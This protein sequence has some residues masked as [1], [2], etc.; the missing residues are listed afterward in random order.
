MPSPVYPRLWAVLVLLLGVCPGYAWGWWYGSEVPNGAD[1]IIDEVRW[2]QWPHRTYYALWNTHPYP[3]GGYLYGGVATHGPGEDAH[4]ELVWTFWDDPSYQPDRV[5]PVNHG[6]NAYGGPMFGEGASCNFTGHLNFMEQNQWYRFVMRTW[7]DAHKPEQVGYMGWWVKDLKHDRWHHV[8]IVRIPN[9]VTG[10]RGQSCFVEIIGPPGKRQIDRRGSYHHFKGQWHATR[11]ITQT[12]ATGKNSTW[13]ALEDGKVWRFTNVPHPEDSPPLAH[14]ELKDTVYYPFRNQAPQPDLE[15]PRI[16]RVRAQRAGDQVLV[17]W[18][19][20]DDTPP[21]L[22]YTVQLL[23]RQGRVLSE[24]TD[25]RPEVFATRIDGAAKAESVKLTLRDIYNQTVEQTVGLGA[26]RVQQAVSGTGFYSGVHYRYYPLTSEG[27][28]PSQLPDFKSIQPTREG[29]ARSLNA[30]VANDAT[31]PYALVYDG[32]IKV[33]KAGVYVFDL[34][35]SDGSRLSIGG[36][37]VVNND[38]LHSAI[39][40]RGGIALEAGYHP[41]QLA[42]F[43]K[44]GGAGKARLERKL[45][46]TWEGPDIPWGPIPSGALFTAAATPPPQFEIAVNVT[47]DNVATITPRIRAANRQ[48]MRFEIFTGKARVAFSE[49]FTRRARVKFPMPI[50]Q[51]KLWGRLWLDGKITVESSEVEASGAVPAD[52]AWELSRPGEDWT[53]GFSESGDEL[54][55]MGDGKIEVTRE[56]KG[57]FTLTGRVADFTPAQEGSGVYWKSRLGLH[58]RTGQDIFPV[59]QMANQDM[60]GSAS[61]RDLETSGISRWKVSDARPWMRLVRRGNHLQAYVSRDQ[62]DW[63]LVIDRVFKSIPETVEAGVS[64]YAPPHYSKT[65][66][67]GTIDHIRIAQPGPVGTVKPTPALKREELALRRPIRVIRGV[68]SADRVYLRAVGPH[69]YASDDQGQTWQ[70]LRL[71]AE[72]RWVRSLAVHPKDHNILL[73]GA[74][75]ET[76]GGATESGLWRSTDGGGTWSKIT[77]AIDFRG[78]TS[79]VVCGEVIAFDPFNPGVVLAGGDRTGV[80]VST[81]AGQTWA[82]TGITDERVLVIAFNPHQ[83][84]AAS[85]GTAAD[86]EWGTPRGD[87]PGRIYALNPKQGRSEVQFERQDIAINNIEFQG[88]GET[89]N[90]M[91]FATTRGVYYCYNRQH[92]FNYRHN[93]RPDVNH[94][95]LSMHP[96]S[97]PKFTPVVTAPL[98]APNGPTTYRGSINYYW[99]VEWNPVE[100]KA[101]LNAVTGITTLGKSMFL[102]DQRGLWVSSDYGKSYKRVAFR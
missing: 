100:S 48:P 95:G 45:D 58:I 21:Q 96:G 27:G 86:G 47:P 8:G 11:A 63:E 26:L 93:I 71:P 77:D 10:M 84:T 92:F 22:G 81:D 15:A 1:I 56:V 7:Q 23:D 2:P 43:E 13:E 78:D 42:Y 12:A 68:S 50:G 72:A 99:Q 37:Q 73:L 17:S 52:S 41:F 67:R 101:K 79:T 80:H 82:R 85:I 76:G 18:T 55:L 16:E 90:Y 40:R 20:P 74:G 53:A 38:G 9:K 91:Y 35:S 33:P 29:Y 31:E 24:R 19:V 46:L 64:L 32:Y 44:P 39:C 65:L 49:D 36:Q 6:P 97:P 75:H 3:E 28:G 57:D 62:K 94:V 60:R 102:C 34:R 14:P 4:L 66:F 30:S 59:W 83:A 88:A 87:Q 70:A 61:D 98:H 69:V 54:T 89:T 51:H 5:R 25:A